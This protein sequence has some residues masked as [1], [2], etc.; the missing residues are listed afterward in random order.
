MIAPFHVGIDLV[1][2]SRIAES[3]ECFG[4]RFLRRIFTEDEIAYA[5][6]EPTRTAERLA[7]RFAAKEATI[8]ALRL[9]GHPI[10]WRDIEV[11][12]AITGDCA[13]ELHGAL[14]ELAASEG[15][16]QLAVSMSH[17]G[18]YATAVV[19]ASGPSIKDL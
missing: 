8:K 14:S 9:A 6:A 18:D 3:L 13:M 19:I 2:V 17:E 1:Q 12:R 10:N 5:C 7:A 16:R 4:E 11:R 15:H